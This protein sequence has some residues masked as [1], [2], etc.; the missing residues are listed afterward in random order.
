M[1]TQPRTP[2]GMDRPDMALPKGLDTPE[3]SDRIDVTGLE[4]R[5]VDR[6]KPRV[7]KGEGRSGW[8]NEYCSL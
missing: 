8:H 4:C 5:W 6:V 7:D 3:S 2:A 1:D